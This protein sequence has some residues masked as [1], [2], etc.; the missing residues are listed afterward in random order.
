MQY[1][2]YRKPPHPIHSAVRNRRLS[3][4]FHRILFS[5]LIAASLGS[6]PLVRANRYAGE[7]LELGVG[8]R[9]LAMGGTV[10]SGDQASSFYWNPALLSRLRGTEV[11]A[12]YVPLF[13]GLATYHVVGIA[14]PITGAAIGLHWVRLSVDK[15]PIWP[16]YSSMSIDDRQRAIR[17]RGGR[18]IGITSDNEDA[19]FFTFAKLNRFTADLGWSYFSLPLEIPAGI[20]VKL[21]R[22]ALYNKRATGIG[23][24]AGIGLRFS[25]ND[26]LG[27]KKLGDINLAIVADDFTRTGI[28]WGNGVEDAIPMNFRWGF[29]YS[30]PFRDW[31]SDVTLELNTEK[32]Y[33]Y[34]VNY[35]VEYTF[36]RRY[37]ARIGRRQGLTSYGAGLRV[38]KGQI[39]Y[40]FQQP[41]LGNQH[42]IG[43]TFHL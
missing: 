19:V 35:G 31:K 43:V 15:I 1:Q 20:N 32:K 2:R 33:D 6:V 9:Q 24:D 39:D 7:F 42:W 41:E 8:P 36:D 14:M 30:Q 40:A 21:V 13:D 26:L 27:Q 3:R 17:E 22:M 4:G 38:W 12:M 10:A 16:D 23:V 18:P 25:M 37:S 34:E 11:N 28:N 29:A 5:L